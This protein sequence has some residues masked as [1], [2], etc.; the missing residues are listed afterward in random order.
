MR[1]TV[2]AA[3]VALTLAAT[4]T[5]TS[6]SYSEDDLEIRSPA[7]AAVG[8][9]APAPAQV[10]RQAEVALEGEVAGTRRPEATLALRDLFATLPRLS[11]ADRAE[12][13]G[14]LARPTNQ[15]GPSG[16]IKYTTR[17]FKRCGQ[18]VCVHRVV[19]TRHKATRAWARKSLR[20]LE[21]VWRT[22]IG[23]LGYRRPVKDGRRGGNGKLDVYLANVGARGLYGY[24]VPEFTKPG[25]PRLASGYCVLDNDFARRQFGAEPIDSLRVTAAHE[26]FHAVQFGYDYLEDPWMMEATATWIE[27]RYAD[28][29]ND[30]RQYL[31]A[32]QLVR[33]HLALDRFESGSAIQYGNWV[34]FEYLSQRFGATIVRRIWEQSGHFRGGGET[35]STE[36]VSRALAPEAPLKQVFAQFSAANITPARSYPEGRSWPEPRMVSQGSLGRGGVA[37]GELKIDHLSTQNT[38][39]TPKKGLDERRFRLQ[40]RID[41]PSEATS[42]MATVVWQQPSGQVERLPVRLNAEGVGSR[43]VPFNRLQTTTLWLVLSNAST[44]FDDCGGEDHT[45]SCSGTPR[46]ENLPFTVRLRVV[47]RR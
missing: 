29:V 31:P 9:A 14:I 28:G 27:E 18:R 30:N 44:R 5:A 4:G 22:E 42:P 2:A 43:V 20:V 41:G 15:S 32:G 3:A 13:R 46:D 38:R 17:S 33:T 1:R 21:S 8:P 11:A 10:L 6:P 39:V 45:Y 25:F 40:V 23:Q 24:C 37:S 7:S 19:R 35:Y 47:T 36:A 16:E 34:F 26:F 12:A